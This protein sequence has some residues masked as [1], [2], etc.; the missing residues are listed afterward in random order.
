MTLN[1]QDLVPSPR[2]GQWFLR[3]YGALVHRI[4]VKRRLG[5]V[6]KICSMLFRKKLEIFV[7]RVEIGFA[8]SRKTRSEYSNVLWNLLHMSFP[9]MDPRNWF[10]C[11]HDLK[12][13]FCIGIR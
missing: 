1:Q 8:M 12:N 11:F 6:K 10:F 5:E 4:Y 3:A 9:N 13:A 7:M 2:E